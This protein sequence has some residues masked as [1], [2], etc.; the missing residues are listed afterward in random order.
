M[1]WLWAAFA[2]L[3]GVAAVALWY[4]ISQPG[5]VVGFTAASLAALYKA[6][7]PVILKAI[8]PRPYTPE[9]LARLRRGEE[10]HPNR[11]FGRQKGE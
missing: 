3:L 9:E 2:L 1:R 7:K 8:A 4:Y 10:P 6:L 5:W 11:P